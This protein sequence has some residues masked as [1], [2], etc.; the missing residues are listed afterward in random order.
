M[1]DL[2]AKSSPSA[3]LGAMRFLIVDS[4]MQELRSENDGDEDAEKEK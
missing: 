2:D 3:F 1:N 4:S